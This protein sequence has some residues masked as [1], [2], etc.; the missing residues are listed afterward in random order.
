MVVITI[1]TAIFV[2]IFAQTQGGPI[3]NGSKIQAQSSAYVSFLR[4][5]G[6]HN[7]SSRLNFNTNNLTSSM[8]NHSQN[9]DSR[10][11]E[12]NQNFTCEDAGNAYG[13]GDLFTLES[14]P[15]QSCVCLADGPR[16][17]ANVCPELSDSCIEVKKDPRQCCVVC[18]KMGCDFHNKTYHV[19][20]TFK[21]MTLIFLF[22]YILYKNI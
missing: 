10:H 18:I 16:C 4:Y 22:K 20:E 3:R 9:L 1:Q 8:F 11:N 15:C 13:P 2:A 14:D 12:T 19:G 17:I 5:H 21:V 6:Y 7:A